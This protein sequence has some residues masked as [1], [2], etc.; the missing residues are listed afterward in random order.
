MTWLAVLLTLAISLHL[1][2]RR[3]LRCAVLSALA[4]ALLLAIASPKAA[5]LWLA[6]LEDQY[7]LRG[8]E[9]N[10]KTRPVVTLAGGLN[11]GYR[12]FPLAQRLSNASKNRALAAVELVQ[13]GGMLV[14]SGGQAPNRRDE[15]EAEAMAALVQ[16]RL[17]D[18]AEL[19]T[20]TGSA[21]TYENV[22]QL[23]TLFEE[24]GL[25]KDIVLVTSAVHMPRAAGVFA[26]RGFTL[27]HHAVDPLQSP[28][29]SSLGLW[30]RAGA[31]EKTDA[32]LHEWVGWLFYRQQGYL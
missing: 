28:A 19:I 30:P 2:R 32:A 25:E 18:G 6:S 7:P 16:A 15:A 14:V 11:G 20:E 12:E 1:A 29:G 21:N 17:P 13:P 5:D 3:C 31:V 9:G 4:L 10:D 22:R 8:C 27:C 26:K 23:A 24:R